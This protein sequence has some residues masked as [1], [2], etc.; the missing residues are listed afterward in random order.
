[1]GLSICS[2]QLAGEAFLEELENIKGNNYK[3]K[4]ENQQWTSVREKNV[5]L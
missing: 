3:K 2:H 4:I 1:V 5:Q